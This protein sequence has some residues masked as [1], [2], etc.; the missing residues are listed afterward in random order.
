M[1]VIIKSVISLKKEK[2]N[3]EK[4]ISTMTYKH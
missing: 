1:R 4:Y 3:Y 2:K